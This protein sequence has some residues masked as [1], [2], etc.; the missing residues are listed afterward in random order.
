[1]SESLNYEAAILCAS[2]SSM[3]RAFVGYLD[4]RCGITPGSR[5][6]VA[7]SGGPDSVALAV[8][9]AAV[10]LRRTPAVIR[11]IIA[12]VDHG[13]RD[14]SGEEARMV[15]ELAAGLGVP[16]RSCAVDVVRDGKGLSAAARDA[17]Y[18]ALANI[19]HEAGAT[20]V[21]TGH[22]ADD[23]SETM[24]LAMARGSGLA[25]IQ[26]M[27]YVRPLDGD[28]RLCRPVLSFRRSSLHTLVEDCGLP[29]CVD[30]GNTSTES[31][32][33]VVRNEVIPLLERIYP[34]ASERISEL[35]NDIRHEC[36]GDAYDA[37]V[38]WKRAALKTI[39]HSECAATIRNASLGLDSTAASCS[40]SHWQSVVDMIQGDRNDP[41]VIEITKNLTVVVDSKEVRFAEAASND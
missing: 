39:S 25:G 22:H 35:A 2:R 31:P 32:R 41:R 15:V 27:P 19:A 36:S 10:S 6:V 37:T 29:Y 12:H 16:S 40:R 13:L 9:S 30:P 7:V 33:S 14:E 8:L 4:R 5:V 28:V 26:G 23:Q 1:M 21:L 11:P 34:G 18:T 24:L 17:R 38:S 20:A 3:T